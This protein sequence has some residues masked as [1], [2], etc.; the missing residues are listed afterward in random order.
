MFKKKKV[1]KWCELFDVKDE[2]LHPG[3][4]SI[5]LKHTQVD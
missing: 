4:L 5:Q 3:I 2:S 1:K